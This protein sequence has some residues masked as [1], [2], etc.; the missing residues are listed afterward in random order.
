[1]EFGKITAKTDCYCFGIVLLQ[2]ITGLKTTDPIL[3]GKSL[4][5]WERSLVY[6]RLVSTWVSW[7]WVYELLRARPLLKD[8]IYPD[9]LDRRIGDSCNVHQLFWTIR[10]AEK[11][12]CK[13]PHRRMTM[14]KGLSWKPLIGNKLLYVEA[15][16]SHLVAS[17]SLQYSCFP[18]VLRAYSLSFNCSKKRGRSWIFYFNKSC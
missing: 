17:L 16:C 11:C 3:G 15:R 4:V 2:L 8:K 9:L 14:D 6:K 13:N 18:L 1:M 12:P 7:M 5:A 10:I